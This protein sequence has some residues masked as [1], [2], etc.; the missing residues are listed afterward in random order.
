MF[1]PFL[2][3]IKIHNLF[4]YFFK[5]EVLSGPEIGSRPTGISP[6]N[7]LYIIDGSIT[8]TPTHYQDVVMYTPIGTKYISL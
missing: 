8:L 3:Y 7:I 6:L 2:T 5:K 4:F 1:D